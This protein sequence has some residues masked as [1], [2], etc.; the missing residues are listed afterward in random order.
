MADENAS[1]KENIHKNR[2]LVKSIGIS[3]HEN[4]QQILQGQ[5]QRLSNLMTVREQQKAPRPKTIAL[6]PVHVH[7]NPTKRGIDLTLNKILSLDNANPNE[8]YQDKVT[9]PTTAKRKKS[10]VGPRKSTNRRK[11]IK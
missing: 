5:R 8:F 3:K 11:M 10:T 4:Q 7:Q 1:L 2:L 9:R 6:R